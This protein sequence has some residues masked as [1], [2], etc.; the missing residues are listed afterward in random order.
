MDIHCWIWSEVTCDLDKA[1]VTL[2]CDEGKGQIG[3]GGEEPTE[4]FDF[5]S[6]VSFGLL[7]CKGSS[8]AQNGVIGGVMEPGSFCLIL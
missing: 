3:M 1:S 8:H 6:S 7:H 4:P 5:K 2:L